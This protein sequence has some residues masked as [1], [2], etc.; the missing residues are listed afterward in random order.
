[1]NYKICLKCETHNPANALVCSHCGSTFSP[2]SKTYKIKNESAAPSSDILERAE[3]LTSV[4]SDS[5]VLFF[6]GDE[7]PLF[8]DRQQ[9]NITFGR[10]VPGETEPTVNLMDYSG[11]LKGVSRLHAAIKPIEKGY[12]IQDLGSTNGTWLNESAL[13]PSAPQRIHNGDKVRMGQLAFYIYFS[14]DEPT[15]RTIFI[16]DTHK[17]TEEMVGVYQLTPHTLITDVSSFLKALEDI[18]VIVDDMT[19]QSHYEMGI[20]SIVAP[21]ENRSISINLTNINKA[22]DIV[23]EVIVPWKREHADAIHNM[24]TGLRIHQKDLAEEIISFIDLDAPQDKRDQYA[25]KLIPIIQVFTFNPMML[26]EMTLSHEL[27]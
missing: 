27:A 3:K 11:G 23:R 10:L 20:N 2:G 9:E 19:N 7:R 8:I 1:M 26:I 4:Y 5:F 17:A 21:K 18:Q 6:V 22:I 14:S 12:V 24:D 16:K 13:L 15:E 25:M